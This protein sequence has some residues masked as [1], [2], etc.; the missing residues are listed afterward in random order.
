MR[1]IEI[2]H[3]ILWD[4]EFSA[5][6]RDRF[7]GKI[8]VELNRKDSKYVENAD[9]YR[10]VSKKP[11][12][13]GLFGIHCFFALKDSQRI[14]PVKKIKFVGTEF[15]AKL[16]DDGRSHTL[17]AVRQYVLMCENAQ[18]SDELKGYAL[19]NRVLMMR[20]CEK[21]K[22]P[23]SGVI[24]GYSPLVDARE[25]IRKIDKIRTDDYW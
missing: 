15:A 18:K 2:T 4:E 6:E 1:N 7:Y 3:E 14:E 11:F 5:V 22:V 17:E 13:L 24:K 25:A 20:L 9:S 8:A 12:D 21:F 23:D 19:E 16:Y 10:S